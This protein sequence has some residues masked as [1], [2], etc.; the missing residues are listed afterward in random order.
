MRRDVD[1]S[2]PCAYYFIGWDEWV[3]PMGFFTL[4]AERAEGFDGML[5]ELLPLKDDYHHF[6]LEDAI[7]TALPELLG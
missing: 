1:R 5:R 6:E 4:M 2:D 7:E 3:D